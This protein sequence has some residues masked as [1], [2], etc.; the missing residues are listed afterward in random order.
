MKKLKGRMAGQELQGCYSGKGQLQKASQG[1][2]PSKDLNKLWEQV[3]RTP[4]RVNIQGRGN[5]KGEESRVPKLFK[6]EP[7]SLWGCS[8]MEG[9]VAGSKVRGQ[10]RGW[11]LDGLA[12]RP[13]C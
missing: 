5:P 6:A 2:R 1:K 13:H 9:Q 4:R 12:C 3:S 7:G 8:R 11:V 10:S